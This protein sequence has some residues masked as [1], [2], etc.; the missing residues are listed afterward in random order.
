MSLTIDWGVV[1]MMVA[2]LSTLALYALWP[3]LRAIARVVAIVWQRRAQLMKVATMMSQKILDGKM[4]QSGADAAATG[5]P[6]T[7]GGLGRAAS[8]EG[9]PPTQPSGPIAANRRGRRA[10][11]LPR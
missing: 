9:V 2:A 1:L 4:D 7:A 5:A 3:T 8:T 6:V 10:M 11:R